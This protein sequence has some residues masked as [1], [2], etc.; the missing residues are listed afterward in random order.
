MNPEIDVYGNKKWFDLKGQWHRTDGP[1]CEYI[2]GVKL[3]F[4][5][6][7]LHRTDGLA[8]EHP[9]GS[10]EYWLNGVHYDKQEWQD[11]VLFDEV[12]IRLY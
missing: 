10:G 4:L 12:K 9:N 6:G 5:H 3:W 7:K 1:A 2:N 11:K 8:I